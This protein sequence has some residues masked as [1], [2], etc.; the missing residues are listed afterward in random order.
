MNGLRETFVYLADTPLLWLWLTLLCYQLALW[1][2]RISGRAA[3]ANPVALSTFMVGGVILI[4]GVSYKQYF[5]GA[6][7][8]HFLLGPTVVALALP[9]VLH[10]KS[11]RRAL[12]P[13]LFSLLAGSAIAIICAVGLAYLFGLDEVL[14]KSV[15]PKSATAPIAMGIAESTGGIASLAAVSAVITGIIGASIATP[16]LNRLHFRD[17]RARGF[18]VGLN[19]HG[20]GTAHA[21]TIHPIAGVYAT[22]GMAL[23]G[24]LTAV[25]TPLVLW[26]V[27]GV[28]A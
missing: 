16:L 17:W 26:R 21:F 15:A 23:N 22:V 3:W 19:C 5:S 24:M 18:A 9:L 28:G 1:L 4:S 2:Q 27:F 25:L 14:V 11:V 7:F 13:L 20:I 6:Q 8:I 10:W 12:W